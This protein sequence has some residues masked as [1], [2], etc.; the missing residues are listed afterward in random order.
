[1]KKEDITGLIVYLGIIVLAV[2]FGLT[3]LQTHQPESTLA[4]NTMGYILYII[5]SV[6]LGALLNGIL[7][8]L[9]HVFASIKLMAKEK[10]N[11][12]HLMV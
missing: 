4:G 3:V 11:S 9:A 5:G 7:F 10:L 12:L 8:E 6:L 1:M 2:I